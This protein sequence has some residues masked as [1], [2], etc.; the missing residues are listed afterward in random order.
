MQHPPGRSV[1]VSHQQRLSDLD[2]PHLLRE[3]RPAS[4]TPQRPELPP[5]TAKA[6]D[7]CHSAIVHA[8]TGRHDFRCRRQLQ[9]RVEHRSV[10][11]RVRHHHRGLVGHHADHSEPGE[12]ER[13]QLCLRRLGLDRSDA[14]GPGNHGGLRWGLRQF[15]Q[16]TALSDDAFS[17]NNARTWGC[18]ATRS[19][20][21]IR[22]FLSRR[23]HHCHRCY[24]RERGHFGNTVQGPS[25]RDLPGI[26][27][28][29]AG[30][31]QRAE[32]RRQLRHICRPQ[33]QRAGCGK[34]GIFRRH[35]NRRFPQVQVGPATIGGVAYGA[36]TV[37][38]C[39]TGISLKAV[40]TATRPQET[41]F[42]G[43]VQGFSL[44]AAAAWF[45]NGQQQPG[46]RQQFVRHPGL[47]LFPGAGQ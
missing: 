40:T 8:R 7:R 47:R 23:L 29:W 27:Q 10:R 33:R 25:V 41:S 24:R 5:K 16:S 15:E 43:T 20:F 14:G 44:A 11:R 9:H 28:R 42:T 26:Q 35:R 31:R 2:G 4:V 3:C 36:N 18:T 46:L 13:R 45:R 38:G 12:H 39:G 30:D 32:R 6:L 17:G 22:H 37:Y 1:D 19:R 34:Y 21:R